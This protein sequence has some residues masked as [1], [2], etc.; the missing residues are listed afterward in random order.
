[1][2]NKTI[3]ISCDNYKLERFKKELTKAGFTKFSIRQFMG[4]VSNIIIE[5]TDDKQAEIHK[6]CLKV[7]MHFK[8][9]N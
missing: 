6:I 7:E 1:M 9:S 5:T 4:D 3:G 8:R 2:K